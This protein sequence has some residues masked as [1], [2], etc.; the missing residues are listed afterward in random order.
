MLEVEEWNRDLQPLVISLNRLITPHHPGVSGKHSL[1]ISL[2]SLVFLNLLLL[3]Y[4][5]VYL[6]DHIS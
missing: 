3:L 1:F 5:E 2:A 4:S 6:T